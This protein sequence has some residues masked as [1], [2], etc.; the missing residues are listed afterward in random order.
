[1]MRSRT[2]SVSIQCDPRRA[3]AYLSDPENIPAWAPGLCTSI[4]RTGGEWVATTPQGP[5]TIRFVEQ[6]ELG[7]LD[8]YVRLSPEVEILNPMRVVPNGKGSE[9]VFTLFQHAGM[10][11]EQFT[12]DAGLV[13]GDL[14]RSK[15]ILE[16]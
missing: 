10:S 1:M 6:N 5:V 11:E 3:Y 14:G 7:V 9:L 4:E 15:A 16:N 2:V 13:E 12:I 8:H